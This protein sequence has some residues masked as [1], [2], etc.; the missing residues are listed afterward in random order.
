M[1]KKRCI[2]MVGEFLRDYGYIELDPSDNKNYRIII[3]AL[4]Q[5]HYDILNTRT[6]GRKPVVDQCL[7]DYGMILPS[8]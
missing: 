3:T 7:R 5:E 1:D 4:R 8:P 2:K 6:G